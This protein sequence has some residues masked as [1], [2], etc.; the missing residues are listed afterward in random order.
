MDLL[1]LGARS[2]FLADLEFAEMGRLAEKFGIRD[3][4]SWIWSCMKLCQTPPKCILNLIPCMLGNW[5]FV[6][7]FLSFDLLGDEYSFVV[8]REYRYF[9]GIFFQCSLNLPFF[10]GV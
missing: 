5:A 3:V 2:A 7:E 1:D 9:E 8:Y 6:D 10:I 4:F